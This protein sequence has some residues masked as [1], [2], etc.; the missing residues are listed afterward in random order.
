MATP[1]LRT[2]VVALA[3]A[4]AAAAQDAPLRLARLFSDGVVLQRGTPIP[5]WGWARPG[6]TVSVALHGASARAVANGQGQWRAL[7]P[8]SAAGGPW[9]L[10]V[11][12]GTTR[13]RVADVLVGDV[14]VAS[15]QSNM[16]FALRNDR[17]A[18]TAIP[19]AHDSLLREFKIPISWSEAPE[20]T[21]AG[22][23]WV[24]ADS[25]HVKGFSAVAYWF[26]RDLRAAERVPI[27]IV[28]ATWGGSAIETWMSAEAQHLP[29]SAGARG[30]AAA[31]ESLDSVRRVM[32]ARF[33]DISRDPGLTDGAAPW[34]DPAL[35]DSAWASIA[36]PALW[37]SQGYD[38]F[39]GIAWYRTSLV[40]APDEAARGATLSLGPVDDDEITWVNGVEVGR[41]TGWDVPR[42][43]AVPAS[44]LRAGRNVIAVRVD[45]HGGG[46]GI[47]GAAGDVRLTTATREL[48]L[49]GQWRFK[50]ARGGYVLDAQRI[51]KIPVITWNAMVRPLLPMAIRGVI[52]YQGE[53]NAN[54]TAQARAYARQFRTLIESWRGTFASGTE[55]RFPFL[56]VQLP[57]YGP[58]DTGT[59]GAG[60]PWALQREA[61]ER[62]LALP[63]TGRAVTID[64]GEPRDIH[65]KDKADVG[66][67]LALVA[68]RVAYG[69]R[70]AASGPVYRSH[71]IRAG[72]VAVTFD[73]AE[74]GL[75]ARGGDAALGAFAVAGADHRWVRAQARVERTR[76]VVWSD[77]VPHPVAVR[78]AW[79]DDPVGAT[80][81]NGAGL[82]AAPFRTDDW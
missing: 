28:N 4:R 82:P 67:R 73:H 23:A 43:Y 48:P 16:E 21:L 3:V 39:D 6:D 74:G 46:G 75:V 53:S 20:D 61:Q 22:G 1:F 9:A 40:L 35:D 44:A 45:D 37:E 52:W 8:A 72:R 29:S 10:E 70:V 19:A 30:I 62:A 81:Y 69:E 68:R 56:W 54:D 32:T 77:A 80:L 49:A 64:V 42:R 14:W 66:H 59:H 25:E 34:A 57:G 65:P 71:V 78:Y 58:P 79:A 18:A 51:N 33:G 60:G 27:G 50:V 31:R 2:L 41:T 15:G 36:V 76:V 17:D 11:S 24:P 26:A 63:A 5:V 47:Y 7:L 55:P 38:G 13:L 12:S